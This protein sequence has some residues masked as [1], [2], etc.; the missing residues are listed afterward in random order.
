MKVWGKVK[1]LIA[2]WLPWAFTGVKIKQME[3]GYHIY[4]LKFHLCVCVTLEVRKGQWA[5]DALGLMFGNYHVD[6]RN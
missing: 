5:L 3:S 1:Y 4:T 2:Y 6:A